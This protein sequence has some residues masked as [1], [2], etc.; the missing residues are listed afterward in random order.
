MEQ[1]E[2]L[3]ATFNEEPDKFFEAIGNA[4]FAKR[5][6][7]L[8]KHEWSTRFLQTVGNANAVKPEPEK[9]EKIYRKSNPNLKPLPARAPAASAK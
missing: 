5:K 4:D 7:H 3:Q 9:H 8:P 1:M 2:Q 6:E